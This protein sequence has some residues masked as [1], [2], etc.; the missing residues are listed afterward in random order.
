MPSARVQIVEVYQF[1]NITPLAY[2][3]SSISQMKRPKIRRPD[4]APVIKQQVDAKF[5]RR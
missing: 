3:L 4:I 5:V 2:C 1:G